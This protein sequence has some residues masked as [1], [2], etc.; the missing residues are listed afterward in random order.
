MRIGIA[1]PTTGDHASPTNIAAMA[2]H[3]EASG[4]DSVWTVERILLPNSSSLPASY[5]VAYDPLDSL[6]WVAALTSRVGLGVSAIIAP[7][8]PPIT[9]ARRLATI[10]QLSDGR[11]TAA[12]AQGHVAEELAVHNIDKTERA[13]RTTEMINVVRA[14]WGPDPVAYSGPLVD[15]PPSSIGP[16]PQTDGGPPLLLAANHPKALDRAARL[17]LGWNALFSDWDSFTA[18][19]DTYRNAQIE[20]DTTGEVVVR[21]NAT[22]NTDALP[23]DEGRLAAFAHRFETAGVDEIFFDLNRSSTPPEAQAALVTRLKDRTS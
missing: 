7:F 18:Q 17:G 15:I 2:H 16:K 19:L 22:P 14:V 9:M 8:H 3:A 10:D 11:L 12:F 5:A 13:A 6:A 21:I 1:L 20:H 23:A 4:L